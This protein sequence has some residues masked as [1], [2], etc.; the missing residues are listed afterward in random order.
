M[1][2][3]TK[4]VFDDEARQ[5]ALRGMK[6]VCQ[7]VSQ[8]LGAA[9]RNILINVAGYPTFST[10]DGVTVTRYIH[11]EDPK[12][13]C[14]ADLIKG[15]AEQTNHRSG[16]GT[17]ATTV[18]TYEICRQAMKYLVTGASVQKLVKGIKY[19]TEEVVKKLENSARKLE[20]DADI[21]NVANIALNGDEELSG[22]ILKAIEKVGREGVISCQK[23]RDIKSS[24]EYL[25]GMNLSVG[26]YMI[27]FL[28]PA[29]RECILDEAYV[30]CYNGHIRNF[31]EIKK[32][33]DGMVMQRSSGI[34]KSVLIFCKEANYAPIRDLLMNKE[35]DILNNCLIRTPGVEDQ[36][37]LDIL[38]DIALFTGGK[39]IDEFG[40]SLHNTNLENLGYAKKVV[41][42]KYSTMIFEGHGEK[43]DIQARVEVI[44]KDME[45]EPN[46]TLRERA[47]T[48]IARLTTGIA[49]VNV[50]AA[51]EAELT[52]KKFRLDDALQSVSCAIESGIVPGGGVAL[53]KA[54]NIAPIKSSL[55]RNTDFTLGQGILLNSLSA[56]IRTILDNA[57][58]RT[59][60]ILEAIEN[61][62][63]DSWGYDVSKGILCDMLEAGIVDALKV[64]KESILNSSSVACELIK[65]Q[66]LIIQVENKEE[67][68]K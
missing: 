60:V 15:A 37:R 48:R 63:S 50:G 17:S 16:D 62:D 18:L 59:D 13:K 2:I 67:E 33:L 7:A 14:G 5:S 47:Q 40:G 58:V 26:P 31:A 51:T 54:M 4:L 57:G 3:S 46:P 61:S 53:L 10:K 36:D 19:A 21:G 41:V 20:S 30:I 66:G 28:N 25:E 23:S 45:D 49:I 1:K 68:K 64:V 6:K 9:G 44:R 35:K 32:L 43:E 42:N 65:T 29:T 12:E 34:V 56:P 39:V 55:T 27:N 8:T 24:L 11:L 52:E 38:H 22:L